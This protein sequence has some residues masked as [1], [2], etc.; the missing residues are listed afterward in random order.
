[1]GH[2]LY[3]TFKVFLDLQKAYDDL[4][5]YRFLDILRAYGVDSRTIGL[6]WIY[7]GKLTM[8]ARA[9]GY[10]GIPLKGYRGVAQVNP[11]SPT[12]F[13]LFI[14]A[15][16]CHWVM[17]VASTKDVREELGLSILDLEAY[18]YSNNGLVAWNQPEILKMKLYILTGIFNQVVLITNMSTTVGMACQPCHAHFWISF[19]VYE[20]QMTGTGPNF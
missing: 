9:C 2:P 17:V 20:G 5:W 8:F 16:I 7:W 4:D 1:M 11:L 10:F 19:E 12:L 15:V 3:I 13:N 14:D 6:L 18:F